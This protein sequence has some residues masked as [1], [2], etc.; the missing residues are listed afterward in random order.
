MASL[1]LHG[2]LRSKALLC[3]GTPKRNMLLTFPC[4]TLFNTFVF[5]MNNALLKG[6]QNGLLFVFRQII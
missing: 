3:P 1:I 5:Q 4:F 6:G 2:I